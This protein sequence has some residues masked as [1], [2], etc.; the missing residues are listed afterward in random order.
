MQQP[1]PFGLG[2]VLT[3]CVLAPRAPAVAPAARQ[4]QQN[5]MPQGVPVPRE[6]PP[7]LP[8]ANPARGAAAID[9]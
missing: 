8:A 9:G 4:L 5:P 7:A 2:L 3:A 1:R 6:L